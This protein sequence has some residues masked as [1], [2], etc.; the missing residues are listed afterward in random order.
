MYRSGMVESKLRLLVMNLEKLD[1]IALA[2]PFN[3]G[4]DKVH[5]CHSDSE[6]EAIAKGGCF[7]KNMEGVKS[8]PTDLG[9]KDAAGNS[10]PDEGN[11]ETEQGPIKVWTTTHY[12][13]IEVHPSMSAPYDVNY[14][15]N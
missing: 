7:G 6:A 8:V 1:T 3:K 4:F 5:Y 12:V 15:P 14:H 11:G 10:P 13:G 9:K 2:H